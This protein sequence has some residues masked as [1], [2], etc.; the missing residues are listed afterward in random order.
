MSKTTSYRYPNESLIL[1]ITLILVG[2]VIIITSTATFCLSGM[3]IIFVFV[4]ALISNR[5]HHRALMQQAYLV[6]HDSAP[7]LA[8]VV[9]LCQNRLE[10]GNVNVYILRSRIINAYTFG[11][12]DPKVIVLYDPLLRI[13]DPEELAF[14]IG[15]EMG[16]VALN[17]TWLN[18]ILGGMAGIPASFGASVILQ[19]AF[20]WWNRT[21]EFSS[22]RAGLL[23]CGSLSKAV[24]ALVKISAPNIRTQADFE[25]ALALIDL[26]DDSFI[27]QMGELFQ[28]HPMITKR[29]NQ[30]RVYAS[31]SDHQNNSFV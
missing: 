31:S 4:M 6:N 29:I 30:L 10:P 13:M 14:V 23:A 20:R 16:H 21:C 1:T 7:G 17:H 28:S 24:S 3:F 8:E 19:V 9:K 11:L 12:G 25:R 26:Q 15:H 2:L 22:D 18:T 27:N 5:N